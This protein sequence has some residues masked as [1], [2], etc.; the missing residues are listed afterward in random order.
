MKFSFFFRLFLLA[1]AIFFIGNQTLLNATPNPDTAQINQTV[2]QNN[3]AGFS[4]PQDISQSK[5]SSNCLEV[6]VSDIT[7]EVGEEFCVSVRVNNFESLQGFQGSIQWNPHI[8]EFAE[9]RNASL[10]QGTLQFGPTGNGHKTLLWFGDHPEGASLPN[11]STIMNLCFTH[12]GDP[13]RSSTVFLGS[14]PT[15]LTAVNGN[16]EGIEVCSQAA[17]ITINYP[18]ML[19]AYVKSCGTKN[20]N[21]GT[22]SVRVFGGEPPYDILL[23]KSDD[24]SVSRSWVVIEEGEEVTFL[25][26]PATPQTDVFYEIHLSDSQGEEVFLTANISDEGPPE[27]EEFEV[28]LPACP[29]GK[30]GKITAIANGIEPLKFE[31]SEFFF[32]PSLQNIGVGT[33][34]L[35]VTDAM[36]CTSVFNYDLNE[37]DSFTIDFTVT[38]PSSESSMDGAISIDIDG[39]VRPFEYL[40]EDTTLQNRSFVEN[41]GIGRYCLTIV[42][43]RGCALFRCVDIELT[44]NLEPIGWE[45]GIKIF[46]NP[47]SD[48]FTVETSASI[49][50]SIEVYNST[51]QLVYSISPIEISI[52]TINSSR[53][54][55]GIY[56]IKIT[57]E[58]HS[59]IK[60]IGI[61]R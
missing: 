28:V 19:G 47:G 3:L 23:E 29:D 45:E 39:G 35:W 56:F 2:S 55:P 61:G 54:S 20:D 57:F 52:S 12:I 31:W 8:L 16:S 60:S 11:G 37:T 36:G 40:W 22:I 24:N 18:E 30:N 43:A 10:P 51:G 1:I 32:D 17:E 38:L 21:D 5:N 50:K 49:P 33:Y 48:Q 59:I 13:G 44:S 25:N 34:R 46:P 27:I 7:L 41:L 26:L 4:D 6:I 58:G 15:L 9:V 42:D 53:W 14:H